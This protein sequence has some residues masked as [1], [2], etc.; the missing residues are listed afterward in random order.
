MSKL[1]LNLFLEMNAFFSL[2]K[3]TYTVISPGVFQAFAEAFSFQSWAW[4]AFITSIKYYLLLVHRFLDP[5]QV[6]LHLNPCYR[7]GL[8]AEKVRATTT[9]VMSGTKGSWWGIAGDVAMTWSHAP[10][11]PCLA[12]SQAPGPWT[13]NLI[14]VSLFLELGVAEFDIVFI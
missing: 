13:L 8:E 14:R 3:A 2:W 7:N 4:I 12:L 1:K 11:T 6:F 9:K 10:H 5:Y